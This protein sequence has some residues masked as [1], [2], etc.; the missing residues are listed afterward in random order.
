MIDAPSKYLESHRITEGCLSSRKDYGNNGAFTVPYD[1]GLLV[2]IMSDGDGW[3]HVSV[4]VD[5]PQHK[6]RTPTW[7]EMCYVKSLWFK[8]SEW[9]LQYH[10]AKGD[11]VNEH[12]ECLHLW[13][14]VFSEIPKP[15]GWM[16]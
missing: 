16:V 10:P 1:D 8:P 4:H 3:E 5:L 15:P 11:Y 7:Q 9:V 13:R 2:M 6:R 12:N 14:P